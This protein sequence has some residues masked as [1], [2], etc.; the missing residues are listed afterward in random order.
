MT[1]PKSTQSTGPGDNM[2][3]IAIK[4]FDTPAIPVPDSISSLHNPTVL[5]IPLLTSYFCSPQTL[6]KFSI[7]FASTLPELTT[8][9]FD[10][11]LE[12]QHLEAH[13]YQAN[14]LLRDLRGFN[15][16]FL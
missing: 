2:C 3:T 5:S 8:H 4:V 13:D 7:S 11:L 12:R 14:V 10:P 1:T 6:Q 9:F 15:D 16:V